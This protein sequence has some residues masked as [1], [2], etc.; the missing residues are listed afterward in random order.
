[1][2]FKNISFLILLSFLATSNLQAISFNL[3]GNNE[4][5]GKVI[6]IADGDTLTIL[7]KDKR[8][9]KIR[10]ASID[11]PEKSQDFGNVSKKSLSD[12]CYGRI[13]SVLVKDKDKYNRSVGVVS[14]D[15][16]EANL[17]QVKRGMAWVY[18]KYASERKYFEAEEE[19][20]SA[21]IGIWSGVDLVPAWE[22][23]KK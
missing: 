1:M 17:E 2:K 12:M 22:F 21:K 23:R 6:S 10:L 14:C 5:S 8:Q 16:L 3:F 18:K 4:I 11:A 9:H 15:G 19:A 7:D 13:A 20:K